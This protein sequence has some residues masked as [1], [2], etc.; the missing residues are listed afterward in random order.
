MRSHESFDEFEVGFGELI[1]VKV[2]RFHP[3]KLCNFE[4]LWLSFDDRTVEKMKMDGLRGIV[5]DRCVE[6]IANVGVDTQL[7]VKLSA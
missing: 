1:G 7:F 5:M 2:G 4:W 6:F 3:A